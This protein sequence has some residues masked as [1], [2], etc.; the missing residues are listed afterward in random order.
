V[1]E[2]PLDPSDTPTPHNHLASAGLD[3]RL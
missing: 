1:Q 2:Q 3:L